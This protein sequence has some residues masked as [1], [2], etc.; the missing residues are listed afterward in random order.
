MHEVR[1]WKGHFYLCLF[2]IALIFLILC[3]WRS[4]YEMENTTVFP[5]IE[6]SRKRPIVVNMGYSEKEKIKL[7]QNQDLD[8]HLRKR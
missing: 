6:K 2:A 3:T 1:S 8:D 7:A 4:E 5:E